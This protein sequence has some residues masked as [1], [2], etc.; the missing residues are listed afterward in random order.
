MDMKTYHCKDLRA[1]IWGQV[2]INMTG[3]AI[4]GNIIQFKAGSIGLTTGRDNTETKNSYCS[5]LET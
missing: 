4:W 1:K 5:I 2:Q 3:R